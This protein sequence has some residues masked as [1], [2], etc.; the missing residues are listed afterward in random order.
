MHRMGKKASQGPELIIQTQDSS[1]NTTVQR[2]GNDIIDTSIGLES[3]VTVG[4]STALNRGASQA[5]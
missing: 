1:H 3:W 4:V 2:I 5:K